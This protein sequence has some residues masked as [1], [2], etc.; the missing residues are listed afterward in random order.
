MTSHPLVHT[1]K[2]GG[3]ALVTVLLIVGLIATLQVF[4]I[5]QQHLLIRRISNQNAAEQS[6]QYGQGVTA[7]ATRVLHEDQNTVVD[8]WGEDWYK[9][10]KPPES[11]EGQIEDD[12]GFSLQ[13]TSQAQQEEEP[14][15]VVDFGFDGL[16]FEISDL[17][18]RFNLNNLQ[19]KNPVAVKAYKTIFLN[20][21]EILEVGEFDERERLYGALLD[22]IDENDLLSANGYESGDYRIKST[23]YY[24][25]DQKL[26]SIG[27]LRF[28]EGFTPELI[29]R[30]K[31]YVTVLPI[32]NARIN[33]NTASTEVVAALS[34]VP[35][36][37]LASV[38]AFLSEREE[39]AFLGFQSA[40]I[41]RAESA[42]IGASA[43]GRSPIP[44]M[45]QT[46]SQFFSINTQVTLGD[47]RYCLRT[48]VL[49]QGAGQRGS[50]G[51][52]VSI[53]GRENDTFCAES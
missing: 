43:I 17:Q 6:F 20:L 47:Y 39:E 15:P 11:Q 29:T 36:S 19:D 45:L 18:S 21:L 8:Y 4:L 27:E 50:A 26:A 22:W 33:I 53:L 37:N 7:W 51:P 10:G 48:K 32:N 52:S 5:E 25:A 3:L 2:Q 13:T 12:S 16:Q 9:F 31:P 46:N 38:S 30:L 49:R 35:V 28:V 24:S 42:I 34:A 40:D 41:Q 1:S 14:M 23:P 44:N